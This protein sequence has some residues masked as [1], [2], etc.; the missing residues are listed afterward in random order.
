[1]KKKGFT[2]IE[3][4][5]V[6]TIL[7]ILALLIILILDPAETIKK[8]RD[9]Q[10]ISD[11]ATLK[12]AII[13]FVGEKGGGVAIGEGNCLL[14]NPC[15]SITDTT[16]L[17]NGHSETKSGHQPNELDYGWLPIEFTSMSSSPISSLP[18]DPL[19]NKSFYYRYATNGSEF[20]FDARLES[21]YYLN[22]V[23]LQ[24]KDGGSCS[25]SY[26][27]GTDLT[28]FKDNCRP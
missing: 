9:V 16:G 12:T 5:I 1:M 23:M 4:L 3:L 24:S 25:T 14:T 10:R 13:L 7:A 27:V 21:K 15:V 20:I 2:L 18:I 6:I 28:L 19:N 26:E 11:M 17:P 8:S 22:S